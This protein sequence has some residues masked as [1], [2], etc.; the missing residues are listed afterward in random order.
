MFQILLKIN[1]AEQFSGVFLVQKNFTELLAGV[2]R[3]AKT[4]KIVAAK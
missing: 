1:A 3:D 4:D 2:T